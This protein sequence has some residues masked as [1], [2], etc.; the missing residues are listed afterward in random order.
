MLLFLMMHLKPTWLAEVS[1]ASLSMT[2]GKQL[3][4]IFETRVQTH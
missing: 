4:Y 1:I 3:V 2:W